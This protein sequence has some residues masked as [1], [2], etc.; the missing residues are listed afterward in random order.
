MIQGTFF[1]FTTK[2]LLSKIVAAS[3]VLCL[4]L[5]LVPRK[6]EGKCKRKKTK[7]GGNVEGK[8]NEGR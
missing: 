5:C 2:S 6:S 7:Q 3:E 1:P 8:N 4:G